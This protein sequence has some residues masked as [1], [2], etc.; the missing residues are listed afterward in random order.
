MVKY[1]L[2][3]ED[4][5]N[6][7]EIYLEALSNAV[8]ETFKEVVFSSDIEIN[9]YIKL[10]KVYNDCYGFKLDLPFEEKML[11]S[12]ITDL[13]GAWFDVETVI[14]NDIVND[15]NNIL[16]YNQYTVY[17]EAISD[18]FSDIE[19]EILKNELTITKTFDNIDL[20]SLID[21]NYFIDLFP[22]KDDINVD[23]LKNFIE[24]GIC[25]LDN[26]IKRCI[27]NYFQSEDY[28]DLLFDIENGEWDYMMEEINR[29]GFIEVYI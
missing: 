29:N 26:W 15:E 10:T 13:D 6:E 21:M 23:T 3:R 25:N 7:S 18:L 4:I 24:D 20:I 1:T 2:K 28:Y 9:N 17:Q 12:F 19:D 14:W 5:D 22:F 27:E 11:Q 16:P 8:N